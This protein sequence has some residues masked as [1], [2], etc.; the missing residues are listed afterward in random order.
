MNF[1]FHPEA[2]AELFGAAVWYEAQEP[3]LGRSFVLEV[4]ATMLRILDFPDAWPGLEGEIRRCLVHRISFWYSLRCRAE[5]CIRPC[6]HAPAPGTRFLERQAQR[7][8]LAHL[9]QF[10]GRRMSD[11]IDYVL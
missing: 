1:S 2:E 6:S 3:G 4:T 5:R 7:G 10:V 11:R 9:P 8:R